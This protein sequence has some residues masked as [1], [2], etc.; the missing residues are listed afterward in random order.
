MLPC[1]LLAAVLSRL[2][3]CIHGRTWLSTARAS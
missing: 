1:I 3:Q 2:R